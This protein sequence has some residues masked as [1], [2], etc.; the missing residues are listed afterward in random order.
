MYSALKRLASQ[1]QNVRQ[2]AVTDAYLAWTTWEW[3]MCGEDGRQPPFQELKYIML[4]RIL[5]TLCTHWGFNNRLL[6]KFANRPM[7]PL[8]RL[9][10]VDCDF[11]L[12]GSA[13]V[14][15]LWASGTKEFK[16]NAITPQGMEGKRKELEEFGVSVT[17][18][19]AFNSL[20]RE[21][22]WWTYGHEINVMDS[23]VY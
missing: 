10:L 18:G 5:G 12:S 21:L 8:K 23:T 20:E 7:I 19:G 3:I 14:K 4:H 22:E 15:A 2:L 9:T 17:Y 1:S 13:V 16:Y 6:E 11:L